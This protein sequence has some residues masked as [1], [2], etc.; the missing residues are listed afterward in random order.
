MKHKYSTTYQDDT[1]AFQ[2]SDESFLFYYRFRPDKSIQQ[3]TFTRG[4]FLCLTRKAASVLK[5]NNQA[6]GSR[7]LHCFGSNDYIDLA[8]RLAGS[9][10]GTIPVTINWQ[11][12]NAETIIYKWTIYK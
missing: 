2:N 12:D 7:I 3:L 5:N 11:A 10:T 8:F 4:D 1:P 6:R 9:I